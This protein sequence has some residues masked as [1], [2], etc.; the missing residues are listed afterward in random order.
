MVWRFG[1]HLT[2]RTRAV[3]TGKPGSSS[4]R[5]CRA[6][7]SIHTY[8]RNDVNIC[9]AQAKAC[10]LE[11]GEPFDDDSPVSGATDRSSVCGITPLCLCPGTCHSTAVSI[12]TR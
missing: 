10:I 12:R 6:A 2:Q 9:L 5:E 1:A 4:L 11:R 3:L 7:A 8:S